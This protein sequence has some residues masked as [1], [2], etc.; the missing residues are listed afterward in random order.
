MALTQGCVH[1]IRML[2]HSALGYFN[3][4]QLHEQVVRRSDIK[5]NLEEVAKYVLTTLLGNVIR[6]LLIFY[7]CVDMQ[8]DLSHILM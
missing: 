8:Y 3:V 6:T 7:L 5:S 2:C 4:L 1:R